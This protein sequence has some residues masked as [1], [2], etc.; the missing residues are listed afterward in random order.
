[1]AFEIGHP[2]I[3]EVDDSRGYPLKVKPQ[4]HRPGQTFL[5]EGFWF[6][7]NKENPVRGTDYSPNNFS[8][9]LT[10]E[11]ASGQNQLVVSSVKNFAK[12]MP[13]TIDRAGVAETAY[14]QSIDVA[15]KTLTL[16][17]NLSNTHAAAKTVDMDQVYVTYSN[18]VTIADFVVMGQNTNAELAGADLQF[19]DAHVDE[20]IGWENV[21][22]VDAYIR[23]PYAVGSAITAATMC[24][25]V[26]IAKGV[27]L[28]V[29]NSMES[30]TAIDPNYILRVTFDGG[31]A[32]TEKAVAIKLGIWRA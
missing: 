9:A 19:A 6:M 1:M 31:G 22:K 16:T 10:Q 5:C 28:M 3:P 12:W 14:I 23:V 2:V 30:A 11:A 20:S 17:A 24:R 29:N 32:K 25:N 18:G 7:A 26:Y 21:E 13:I 8:T 4:F 15:N 27:Q